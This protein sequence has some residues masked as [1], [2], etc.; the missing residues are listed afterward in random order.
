MKA[1]EKSIYADLIGKQVL[2]RG[3]EA[4]VYF[5]T[6]EAVESSTV[7]LSNVRNIWSWGGA[8][9]LSQVAEEGIK[10]GRVSQTVPSMV[11]LN[12]CQIIPLS[13]AATGNL[14]NQPQWKA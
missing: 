4:G 12:V 8:T 13:E 9:C 3:Y 10:N 11:I 1:N 6:L 7:R 5:G 14:N 2:V